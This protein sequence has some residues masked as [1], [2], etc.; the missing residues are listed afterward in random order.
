M[1]LHNIKDNP[2]GENISFLWMYSTISKSL[3]G[4]ISRSAT[5]LK[6][7]LF[8]LKIFRHTKID[9]NRNYS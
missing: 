1:K 7:V 3:W 8:F 5:V 9:K 4:H 6:E 2:K